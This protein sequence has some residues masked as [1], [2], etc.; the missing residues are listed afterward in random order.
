MEIDYRDYKF[1][2][3]MDIRLQKE[4]LEAA[5]DKFLRDKGWK[6]TSDVCA[7]WLWYKKING[8]EIYVNKDTAL[9]LENF[10]DLMEVPNYQA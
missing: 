1:K 6:H 4:Q 9:S 2:H 8:K 3:P 10:S 7:H 5:V